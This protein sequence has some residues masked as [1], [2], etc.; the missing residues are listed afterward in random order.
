[1]SLTTFLR[2]FSAKNNVFFGLF[3]EMVENNITMNKLFIE[4]IETTDLNSRKELVKKIKD[5]EH[6]NDDLTRK[7]FTEL[8]LTFITP[9]DREDIHALASALDDIADYIDV[10]AKKIIIFKFTNLDEPIHELALINEKAITEVQKAVNGLR[11]MKNISKI[12][13]SCFEISKNEK[14]A[15]DVFENGLVDLLDNEKDAATIIKKHDILQIMEFIS[16]KC[17]DA[18]DVIESIIIKYA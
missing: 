7:I 18:A 4:V 3:E 15:D 1:M 16:D 17:E 12:K 14:L 9:F 13:E 11:N 2:S 8:G 6:A 10:A 5:I